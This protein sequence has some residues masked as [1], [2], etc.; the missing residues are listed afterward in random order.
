[1]AYNFGVSTKLSKRLVSITAVSPYGTTIH[2]LPHLVNI[3]EEHRKAAIAHI[4]N[5]RPELLSAEAKHTNILSAPHV[6]SYIH[7]LENTVDA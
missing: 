1:M 7:I 3:A 4:K 6:H 5:M 2:P